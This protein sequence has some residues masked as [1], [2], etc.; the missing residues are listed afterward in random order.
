MTSSD[1]QLGGTGRFPPILRLAGI[2]LLLGLFS[3]CALLLNVRSGGITILWPSNGLLLGVLLLTSRR[4]WPAYVVVGVLVDVGINLSL[5]NPAPI[6]IYLAGCNMVEV[7]VAAFLLYPVLVPAPDLTRKRQLVFFLG[8]GVILAPAIAAFLASLTLQRFHTNQMPH[9]FRL[10]FTA[11][12][13]G[14]STV[15][16]LLLSPV[17]N[18]HFSKQFLSRLV[19]PFVLLC[20]VTV[21]VF[22]RTDVPLLFMILPC[23]ILMGL[24]LGLAG[25]SLGL[26]GV[27]VIGGYFTTGGHGP[28][29]LMRA[30]SQEDHIIALQFFIAVSMLSVYLLEVVM[31]ESRRLQKSLQSSEAYFRLLAETSRDV[32]VLTDLEGGRRYVSPAAAELLGWSPEELLGGSYRDLVHPDDLGEWKSLLADSRTGTT[33]KI[34]QYRCRKKDGSY[35]WMESNLRLYHD[36]T[37]GTPFGFVNVVRDISGRKAAEEDLEK[38][39]RLVESLASLDGLTEIA[40]RRRLD[41]VLEHEWRL[42]TRTVSDISL[43]LIDVDHFKAYNDIYGHLAGDDCLRRLAKVILEMVAR[44]SDLVARYGGEEFAVV[45]PNTPPTGAMQVA[46]RIRAAVQELDMPHEG[47]THRVVTVSIGCA[48]QTPEMDSKLDGLI[49]AADH[50]LYRAKNAG[51]NAIECAGQEVAGDE[52]LEPHDSNSA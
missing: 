3:Y 30:G 42:A 32:I 7:L 48:T 20:A 31:A 1:T 34:L 17:E 37:T 40:N 24:R 2:G 25:S 19:G 18:R 22:W 36:P 23:L 15:T 52:I 12:A 41:Q 10:W 5:A 11:D 51:R 8:Y 16:P 13:L 9:T 44:P 28:T 50:A 39:F 43:L 29:M 21:Y 14:I 46:D 6:S 33:G 49:D 26:L 47:N 4:Q 38:A 27:S 45:L 35:L